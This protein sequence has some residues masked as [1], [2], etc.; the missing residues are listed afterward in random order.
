MFAEVCVEETKN[1]VIEDKRPDQNGVCPQNG[2]GKLGSSLV[3]PVQ[4]NI[5]RLKIRF[6][7]TV[8]AE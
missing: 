8:N 6:N 1:P 4:I 2:T 5:H 7:L 3:P